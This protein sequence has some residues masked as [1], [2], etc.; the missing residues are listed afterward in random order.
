V[1]RQLDPGGQQRDPTPDSNWA[2][3]ELDQG[4]PAGDDPA[5]PPPD[6]DGATT[7][8]IPTKDPR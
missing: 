8:D 3:A 5:L 7:T 4:R 6:D 1:L 2:V